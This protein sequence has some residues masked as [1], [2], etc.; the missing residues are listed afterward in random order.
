MGYF[1]EEDIERRE[2]VSHEDN[3]APAT[4]TG[5][6]ANATYVNVRNAPNRD[7]QPIGQLQRGSLVVILDEVGDYYKIEYMRYPEAYVAAHFIE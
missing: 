3:M 6:V 1:S 4:R 7:G 2:H 5:T